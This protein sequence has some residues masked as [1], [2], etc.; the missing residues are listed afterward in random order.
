MFIIQQKSWGVWRYKEKKCDPWLRE[1]IANKNTPR[2]GTDR[3]FKIIMTS[4]IKYV[5]QKVNN[6]EKEMIISEGWKN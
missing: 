3:K 2:N 6:M 4:I 5:V 1:E